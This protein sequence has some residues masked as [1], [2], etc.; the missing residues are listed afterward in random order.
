MSDHIFD[1][2]D[3]EFLYQMDDDYALG[4]DGHIVQNAGGG[5]GMDLN[6]GEFHMTSGWESVDDQLWDDDDDFISA[7][8]STSQRVQRELTPEE[9]HRNKEATAQ[10]QKNI[11]QSV[12]QSKKAQNHIETVNA[13]IMFFFAVFITAV[14]VVLLG[15]NQSVAAFAIIFPIVFIVMALIANK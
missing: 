10:I 6:T 14:I 8:N 9:I 1:L 2:D 12:K 11:E 7:G 5:M 3:G 13:G 15:L 4:S